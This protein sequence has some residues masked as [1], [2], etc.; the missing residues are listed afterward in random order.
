MNMNSRLEVR[1]EAVRMAMQLKEATAE[2]IIAMAREIEEYVLSG[3]ELPDV[4]IDF[5]KV[6]L[7]RLTSGGFGNAGNVATEMRTGIPGAC[8]AQ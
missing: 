2:N 5:Y 1:M 7:E 3:I 8:S 6:M 4:G